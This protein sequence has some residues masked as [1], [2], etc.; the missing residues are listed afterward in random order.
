MESRRLAVTLTNGRSHAVDVPDDIA[1][2]DAAAVL[3]GTRGATDV[4]WPAGDG[5]WLAFGHGQGWVRRD[6]IAE[7]AVVDYFADEQPYGSQLYD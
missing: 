3:R 2:E 5:E 7:I 4:G 6:A 1:A